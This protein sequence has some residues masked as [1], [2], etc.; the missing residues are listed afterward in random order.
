MT[1]RSLAGYRSLTEGG[2]TQEEQSASSGETPLAAFFRVY[3]LKIRRV[4][5]LPRRRK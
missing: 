3:L 2:E 1:S 5:A 4:F